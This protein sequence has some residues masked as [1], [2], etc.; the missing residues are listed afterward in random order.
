MKGSLGLLLGLKPEKGED[1]DDPIK[2]ASDEAFDALKSNDKEAFRGAM[3]QL[4]RACMPKAK[5]KAREPDDDDE[6]DE[7]DTY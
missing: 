3:E 4:V 5:P 6:D 2:V 1:E 7:R